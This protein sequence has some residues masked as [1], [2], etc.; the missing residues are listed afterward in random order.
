MKTSLLVAWGFL[1]CQISLSQNV[2]IGVSDPTEKLDVNGNIRVRGIPF[3]TDQTYSV[4]C[5]DP[6]G[7]IYKRPLSGGSTD[8]ENII[9]FVSGDTISAGDFIAIGDGVSGIRNM[10]SWAYPWST[11][12]ISGTDWIAQTFVTSSNSLGIK[13]IIIDLEIQGGGSSGRILMCS[14][15]NVSGGIPTGTDINGQIGVMI[16]PAGNGFYYTAGRIVFDPPILIYPSTSY[17]FIIRGNMGGISLHTQSSSGYSGGRVLFSS[18]SGSSWTA[19]TTHDINFS[20]FETYTEAGKAYRT[21][22]LPFESNVCGVNTT[23]SCV[24]AQGGC[25]VDFYGMRDQ[26]DNPIG[27]ALTNAFPGE[28]VSV[29]ISGI[30]NA[31]SNFPIG[32]RLSLG[33]VPGSMA[34]QNGSSNIVAI[35]VGNGV[36]IS[37]TY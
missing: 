8:P 6:Y 10:P 30:C 22:T 17:A 36:I 13:A 4:M 7:K 5:V 20:V 19:Q 27:I 1:F 32:K 21:D 2:G 26:R 35:S 12:G 3:T 33:T 16:G 15:R 31:I 23:V 18:N 28:S 29:Q 9:T 25:P 24:E 34:P 11:N 14:I 37:I